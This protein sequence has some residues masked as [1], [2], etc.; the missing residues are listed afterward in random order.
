[1]ATSDAPSKLSTAKGRDVIGLH[2]HERAPRPPPTY[3]LGNYQINWLSTAILFLPPVGVVAAIL[4]GVPLTLPTLIV[5][6]VFYWLNGCIGITAGY[7]RLFAHRAF[8]SHWTVQWAVL[9]FGAGAFEGSAKWWCRNH[10]IHHR[11]I[12]TDKDPYNATRGFF[13]T[14]WGWMVMK[15]DYEILGFVET[16]DLNRNRAVMFQHNY[17]LPIAL[18]SGVILP[19]VLCGLINGD[20]VGGYMYA[21]LAKMFW[22]HNCTFFINSLAHSTLFGATQNFSDQHSSRDSL[23]CALLTFGEGYHNFHHEFAQ[24]YRNGIKWFHW[25]PTKW[26][27]RSLEIIGLAKNLVRTPQSVIRRNIMALRLKQHEK[28]VADLHKKLEATDR[29]YQSPVKMTIEE[30]K[31]RVANGSK[32]VIVSGYVLDLEKTIATG[33]GYT[34]PSKNVVWYQSHPGGRKVLDEYVGKDATDAMTGGVYR[35]SE[36]ALNLLLHLR[37]ASLA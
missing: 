28:I 24:D 20:W 31:D 16:H 5:A 32:L 3:S 7:H 15:Q 37:I 12:D 22:T 25:D 9:F 21:A 8:D 10:R 36:G 35:H 14:H 1:M 33:K 27:I 34:T 26:V 6:L 4:A 23:L 11:Y 19:T 18:L 29:K 30:F 13:Y 2:L 17:Y